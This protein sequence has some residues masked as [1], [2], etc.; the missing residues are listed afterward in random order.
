ML[1]FVFCLALWLFCLAYPFFMVFWIDSLAGQLI[2]EQLVLCSWY[3]CLET[4]AAAAERT[5]E[6]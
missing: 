6:A 2:F 1:V 5:R 3:R 4:C